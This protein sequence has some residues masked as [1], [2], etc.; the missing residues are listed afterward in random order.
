[1][2]LFRGVPDSRGFSPFE[3]I[4][5]LENLRLVKSF[6][7]ALSL[8]K[9]FHSLVPWNVWGFSEYPF[10]GC[11]IIVGNPILVDLLKSREEPWCKK[12]WVDLFSLRLDAQIEYL[13]SNNLE[14][15][16]KVTG[17]SGNYILNYSFSIRSPKFTSLDESSL[18]LIGPWSD[19][20]DLVKE[21]EELEVI[22]NDNF[23]EVERCFIISE[24]GS[25]VPLLLKATGDLGEYRMDI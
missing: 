19:L 8:Y 6:T 7:D 1:M 3:H 14:G 17:F 21:G 10:P 5:D 2:V 18:T 23:A 22:Y 24:D 13:N 11:G 12:A 9:G 4:G 15:F 20:R 25:L 16:P